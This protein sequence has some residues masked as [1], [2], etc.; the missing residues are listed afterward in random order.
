MDRNR[1]EHKEEDGLPYKSGEMI[2]V[3]HRTI[4]KEGTSKV[5][6]SLAVERNVA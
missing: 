1:I 5:Y 2:D 4:P 3:A 6:V